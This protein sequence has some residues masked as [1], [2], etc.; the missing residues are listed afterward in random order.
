MRIALISDIHGNSLALKAVLDD[1]ATQ[2]PVDAHW[3]LGD[4]VAIGPDPV[5]VMRL[6]DD[7]PNADFIRGNTDRYTIESSQPITIE[8]IPEDPKH[9]RSIITS[10]RSFAW[11]AGAMH[12]IGKYEWLANLSF[13][14]RLI[15]P[16]GTRL[17]CVHATPQ[18]DDGIG[19]RPGLTD[20]EWSG[21]LADCDADLLIAG[22]THWAYEEH[23]NGVHCF[24]LGST[25]NSQ[26]PDLR[27][28]YAVL[29]ADTDTYSLERR[30]VEYDTEA[31]IKMAEDVS[32][33]QI[34]VITKFH[35]GEMQQPWAKASLTS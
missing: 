22:H 23:V 35:R 29:S 17:L 31:V 8:D 25:S 1:L 4:H 2:P 14:L 21:M 18:T 34:N 5:G 13:D 28:K 7:V 15:L 3:F 27:A 11:T 24:N 33:P 6:L 30:F 26:A 10:T 32:H 16:D 19:I 9:V 12:A 20:A